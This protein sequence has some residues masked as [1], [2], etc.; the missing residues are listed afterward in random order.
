[1]TSLASSL[2]TTAVAAVSAFAAAGS[3]VAYLFGLRRSEA[4]AARDEALALARTRAEVIAELDAKLRAAER[5]HRR[6]QQAAAARTRTLEAA[7]E[8][9]RADA[10]EQAYQLQRFYA[11]A[12]AELVEELQ[13]ELEAT[14]PDVARA[15]ARLRE[16][17]ARRLPAA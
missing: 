5:R 14:P 1:M 4:N 17:A 6:A 9:A 13:R 3:L 11:F 16:I 15:R 8:S 10:R 2:V 12:F 7:V